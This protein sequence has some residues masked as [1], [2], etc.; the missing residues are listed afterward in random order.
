[1]RLA[2]LTVVG[3]ASAFVASCNA[4]DTLAVRMRSV[5]PLGGKVVTT[6]PLSMTL[7]DSSQYRI[8]S[9]G[10]GAYVNGADGMTAEIDAYG[11]L[12]ISPL[13]GGS[14]TPA[15]RSLTFDYS[16]HLDGGTYVIN[17]VGQINFKILSNKVNNGNPGIDQLAVGS[18]PVSGCY[19][20]TFAH[21]SPT[22]S[23][24]SIFNVASNAASTYIRVTRT[25]PGVHP[26][27]WS[28]VTNGGCQSVPNSAAVTT[29][30][31]VKGNPPLVFR[32]YYDQSF[33]ITLTELVP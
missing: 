11:N 16:V 25:N 21:G 31:Q 9:D 19:N 28:L 5:D 4:P 22:T 18:N 33:V 30:E 26:A 29:Q 24:R 8:R 15:A 27:V 14:A 17:D 13:N 23:F 32:G 20:M 2:S 7:N 1:M 3:V 12:L 10:Q 6:T